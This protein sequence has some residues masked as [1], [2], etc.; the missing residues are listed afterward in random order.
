M[1]LVLLASGVLVA[2]LLLA[3]P[4][5]IGA[6]RAATPTPT[7][8][9]NLLTNAGFE[10][11]SARQWSAAN[12][13]WANG[14]I[15]EGWTAWWRQPTSTDGKYPN[16]CPEDDGACQPWHQPEYRETK[17][18]PY[19]PPRIRSGE[20]S[21]MF[22]ASFGLFEGGI[23]Q[24]VSGAPVGWRVRF[25]LWAKAWSNSDSLDTYRSSGQPGMHM[26][27]GIDPS[28][29]VDPWSEAIVWGKDSDSFDQFS[30]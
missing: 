17:G 27:V 3:Q 6:Q 10:N 15:A 20:N 16:P 22:G 2:L 18:I 7:L 8:P 11:G 30:L 4:A 23:Y 28:G 13:A 5:S 9:P 12:S 21:Q 29:G 24:K 26:R 14:R 25:S 1:R 19:A